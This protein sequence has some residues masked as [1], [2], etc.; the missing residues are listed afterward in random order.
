MDDTK[1]ISLEQMRAFVATCGAV[2]LQAEDRV[3]ITKSA[4]HVS[5]IRPPS[6]TYFEVLRS[7]LKWGE[8]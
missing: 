4:N 2:E 5:L 6:K 7:K 3:K 1:P 8:R